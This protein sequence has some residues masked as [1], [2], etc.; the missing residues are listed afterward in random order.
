[1]FFHECHD[2]HP[3]EIS[4]K[5]KFNLLVSDWRADGAGR[6]LASLAIAKTVWSNFRNLTNRGVGGDVGGRQARYL[7][8]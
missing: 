6:Q 8:S 1:M 4:S 3:P 5:Y 2:C 7:V